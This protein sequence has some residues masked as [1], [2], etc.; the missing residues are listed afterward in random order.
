MTSFGP[1]RGVP[2]RSVLA[3]LHGGWQSRVP[4][5]S[6][7]RAVVFVCCWL[8]RRLAAER[9][10]ENIVHTTHLPLLSTTTIA[11]PLYLLGY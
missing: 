1:Q 8:A 3:L 9:V 7:L 10:P 4:V 2:P 6:G 11:P 5:A